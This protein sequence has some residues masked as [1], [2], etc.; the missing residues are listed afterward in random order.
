MMTVPRLT[1]VVF[2]SGALSCHEMDVEEE[3]EEINE[4]DP[5]ENAHVGTPG[6]PSIPSEPEPEPAPE[7][8]GPVKLVDV[9]EGAWVAEQLPTPW[10]LSA[11]LTDDV[12]IKHHV[13]VEAYDGCIADPMGYNPDVCGL[14][15][16]GARI[17]VAMYG[18]G[19]GRVTSTCL[20]AS[21]CPESMVCV[22][23]LG[24]GDIDEAV[25]G[26]GRC[27]KTCETDDAKECVRSDMWCDVERGICRPMTHKYVG[28]P[29][30]DGGKKPAKKRAKKRDGRT[31][32]AKREPK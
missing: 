25:E 18:G 2:V 26:F 16:A 14:P 29:K 9:C 15:H 10:W 28:A 17:C 19:E 21:D 1:F 23:T 4:P 27:E 12:S 22:G 31:S 24:P 20:R 13:P 5:Q 30:R 11:G 8:D 6:S 32:P 3:G 7:S